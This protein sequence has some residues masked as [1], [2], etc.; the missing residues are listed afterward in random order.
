MLSRFSQ[1]K[2]MPQKRHHIDE[3]PLWQPCREVDNMLI[4]CSR[5]E[6]KGDIRVEKIVLLDGLTF[7]ISAPFLVNCW[8]F[9]TKLSGFA[10]EEV[11]SLFSPRWGMFGCCCWKLE[12][13]TM[14]WNPWNDACSIWI[15][16]ELTW[17]MD[18]LRRRRPRIAFNKA[19]TWQ[20]SIFLKNCTIMLDHTI[21]SG[22]TRTANK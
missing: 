17:T 11:A 9:M 15:G 18:K 8:K 10:F 3:F 16:D 4:A 20:C 22:L 21:M 19:C 13:D 1:L 2:N 5:M 7:T 14:G 12:V 6:I